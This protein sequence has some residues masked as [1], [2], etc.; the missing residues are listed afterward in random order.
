LIIFLNSCG[1]LAAN[2]VQVHF[3]RSLQL[4]LKIVKNDLAKIFSKFYKKT[5]ASR[6]S[7]PSA[8]QLLLSHF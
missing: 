4:C 6:R 1:A 2:L 3:Q 8:K 7:S 5:L